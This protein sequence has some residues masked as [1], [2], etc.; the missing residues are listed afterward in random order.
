ME[1]D[2]IFI[3]C[4]T[5][6]QSLADYLP[7]DMPLS[8]ICYS[9]NVASIV[10]RRPATQVM[11][12]GGL[13]HPSSQSFSSDDGLSYLRRLGINKAFIS[14]GG[15][16]WTRG[17]SCSN[18]HEV[19]IKQAVIASAMESV[20]VVDA[21]KLGSLKPASFADI[22]AFSRI[23]VGGSASSD[24]RKHFRGLPVEYVTNAT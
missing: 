2:T 9:L 11:L 5:T 18:F 16:H 20:L 14:A 8:V 23:I 22:G 15:V 3:D 7:E 1:G 6:M 13:Y 12:M 4:G 21:S 24:M 19:A 10:T 17:A